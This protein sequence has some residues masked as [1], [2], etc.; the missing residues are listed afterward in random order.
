VTVENAESAVVAAATAA[1][2]PTLAVYFQG[3]TNVRPFCGSE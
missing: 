3:R 1:S 2:K